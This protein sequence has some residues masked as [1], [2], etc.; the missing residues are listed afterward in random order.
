VWERS[1]FIDFCRFLLYL[2]WEEMQAAE[3]LN[4]L[5]LAMTAQKL[6]AV[7]VPSAD[8]HLS[9]YV[10]SVDA[11]R[12]FLSGFTGSAGTAVVTQ[13]KALLWTDGRY[14]SQALQQLDQD[15]WNLMR[16]SD[17]SVPDIPEWLRTELHAG[18]RVGI[19]PETISAAT[20]AKWDKILLGISDSTDDRAM[21]SIAERSQNDIDETSPD[22]VWLVPIENDLVDDVWANAKPAREF[23]EVVV[24]P[25]AFAGKS[26]KEKLAEVRKQLADAGVEGI[27]FS[28][29]DEIAWLLNLRGDDI[30]CTPVFFAYLVVSE[31]ETI[32][33]ASPNAFSLEA[34]EQLEEELGVKEILPY[35]SLFDSAKRLGFS[36]VLLDIDGTCLRLHRMCT[37]NGIKTVSKPSPVKRT[38]ALKNEIELAGIKEAHIL[39]GAAIAEFFFWLEERVTAG[40]AVDE[41]MASEKLEEIRSE[42]AEYCGPSFDTISAYGSNAAIVHYKATP[43]SSKN[44]GKDSLYLCDT[45][46]QYVM[47]TT[48]MTRT[49]CFGEPTPFQK[50]AFTLVLEG[51]VNLATARFPDQVE[52]AK[53]DVL[54]RA[55]LWQHGL[56]YRHGTG[57]GLGAHLGVHEFP[58]LLSASLPPPKPSDERI[59]RTCMARGMALSN[60]PGFYADGQFGIR[61]E[62]VMLSKIVEDL[63]HRA[64]FEMGMDWLEFETITFV[65]ISKRLIDRNSISPTTLK[66]LNDYHKHVFEK[67]GLVLLERGKH[68]AYNWL[69]EQ[70]SSLM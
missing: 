11:R 18:S 34:K 42:A 4:R 20:A 63:T 22:Q 32:L 47:G 55:P 48:D 36:K 6:A 66:W 13:E 39:E 29:L 5:R 25:L 62:N 38:K 37:V 30:H 56:D 8:A 31:R 68:E 23:N 41:M 69:K 60:E 2:V 19:N 17:P 43:K 46:G 67:V 58:P 65:P 12:E 70:T 10:A 57:H 9:E 54:A 21:K 50:K 33:F 40:D 35:E 26:S 24:H 7:I 3:K 64:D 44:I 53:L 61:T 49:L 28:A 16:A 14:Y 51:H 1:C 15:C 45:G 27:I 59:S 52:P